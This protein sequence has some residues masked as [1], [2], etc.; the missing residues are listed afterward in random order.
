MKHMIKLF[1][2]EKL[3]EYIQGRISGFIHILSGMPEMSYSWMR[4]GEG[5]ETLRFDCTDEQFALIKATIDKQY[6]GVIEYV[7]E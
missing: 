5:I 2:C 4:S 7:F 3:N 1:P 6:G